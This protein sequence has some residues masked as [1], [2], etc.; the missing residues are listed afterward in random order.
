MKNICQIVVAVA[1]LE[2]LAAARAIDADAPPLPSVETILERLAEHS[3]KEVANEREFKQRY[4]FTRSRATEVR[5]SKG[6]VNKREVKTLVNKPVTNSGKPDA[7]AET[8]TKQRGK[9]GRK[10]DFAV[11]REFLQRFQFTLVGRESINGR[12][13]LI[14]AKAL[15]NGHC[16]TLTEDWTRSRR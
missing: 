2:P 3:Q 14:A 11:D 13:A 16:C 5:N 8:Q 10:T 1:L 15:S 12:P 6:E 7:A 4:H 9:P